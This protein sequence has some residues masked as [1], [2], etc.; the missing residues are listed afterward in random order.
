MGIVF[1]VNDEALAESGS[2]VEQLAQRVRDELITRVSLPSLAVAVV[3]EGKLPRT[4]TGKVRRTPTRTMIEAGQLAT[5]YSTGFRPSLTSARYATRVPT[6][7]RDDTTRRTANDMLTR[8]T[9]GIAEL[10][11]RTAERVRARSAES[12]TSRR[13]TAS[14]VPQLRRARRRRTHDRAGPGCGGYIAP[15]AGPVIAM[16][17]GLLWADAVYGILAAGLAFVPTA[18][19]GYDTGAAIADAWRRSPMRLRHPSSSPTA[20]CMPRSAMRS[21]PSARRSC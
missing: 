18:N 11:Q 17:P 5:L 4:P 1:E 10:W 15:A 19:S 14:G 20:P 6:G 13:S 2:S 9:H 21:D 8:N 12:G 16:S 3:A 7:R